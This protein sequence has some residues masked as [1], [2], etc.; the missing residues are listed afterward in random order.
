MGSTSHGK[1]CADAFEAEMRATTDA[2]QYSACTFASAAAR[3]KYDFD[4]EKKTWTAKDTGKTLSF[5]RCTGDGDARARARTA[6]VD[7]PAASEVR[8]SDPEDSA[9]DPETAALMASTRGLRLRRFA[10][11][12]AAALATAAARRRARELSIASARL[13]RAPERLPAQ[14][15]KREADAKLPRFSRSTSVPPA[16]ASDEETRETEDDLECES[17]DSERWRAF[18]AGSGDVV[19]FDAPEASAS[20]VAQWVAGTV[21]WPEIRVMDLSRRNRNALGV[22][23]GAPGPLADLALAE[24]ARRALEVLSREDA[25]EAAEAAELQAE[26]SSPGKKGGGGVARL[27]PGSTATPQQANI[28]ERLVD[29]TGAN[30]KA[31]EA[32]AAAVANSDRDIET[33]K[34][35]L[36]DTVRAKNEFRVR[37]NAAEARVA[38]L[39]AALAAAGIQAP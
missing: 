29:A 39:E 34:E 10:E 6:A 14:N 31:R 23:R 4:F 3:V 27:P 15:E 16:S 9:M 7:A 8:S 28:I 17:S 13:K 35:S 37:A 25:A 38:A 19:F 22:P 21:P 26:K 32:T 33:L 2:P 11:S 1:R 20:L 36:R 5:S 18:R 30:G 12:H 24:A